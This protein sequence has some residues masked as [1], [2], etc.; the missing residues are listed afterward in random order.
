MQVT[1]TYR[2]ARI[3]A[4]KA[5]EVTRVI[6]GRSA[7]DALD[8]LTFSPKKAAFLV[9]KTLKSAIANAEN[10][11]SLK[12]DTLRVQEAVVGEGP[13]YKRFRARARGSASPLRKRTSHIRIILSDETASGE[14]KRP[15][16]EAVDV[17]STQS[18]GEATSTAR[19]KQRKPSAG[20]SKSTRAAKARAKKDTA[21]AEAKADKKSTKKKD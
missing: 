3:S 7:S 1:S 13:T 12:V 17:A 5:R 21:R 4:F 16:Q 2:Y 15:A 11:A 10:N 18:A 8:L 6:Q 19:T 9:K 14:E 20:R